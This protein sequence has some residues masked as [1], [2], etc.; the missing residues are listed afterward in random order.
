M[1]CNQCEHTFGSLS[2]RYEYSKLLWILPVARLEELVM[3]L[4]KGLLNRYENRIYAYFQILYHK[5][6][7][8]K[9]TDSG[10]GVGYI[11]SLQQCGWGLL[12]CGIT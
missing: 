8:V 9:S 1:W 11:P 4:S 10:G 5:Y 2:N 6:S 7:C 12:D 3:Y